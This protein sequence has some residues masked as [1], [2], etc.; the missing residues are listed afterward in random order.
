[1]L[2]DGKDDGISCVMVDGSP[3]SDKPGIANAI[4]NF[5]SS[6]GR[7]L[8]RAFTP[9]NFTVLTPQ[10]S[11]DMSFQPVEPEY[12]RKQL[13]QLSVKKAT[14]LDGIHS[15]LLKAGADQIYIPLAFI[16]NLSMSTGTFPKDWKD[17]RVTPIFK[18]GDRTDVNN[19]R[20]VSILP[21]VSKLL[22]KVVHDQLYHWLD[23]N[24]VLTE[25]QS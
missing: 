11:A 7:V 19:Y 12:I 1:M 14:G 13:H 21:V 5:F 4:N 2:G 25:W 6:I 24:A 15:R 16:C 8:A 23:S 17:A 20:P 3:V 18:A 10:V 22:E 9:R